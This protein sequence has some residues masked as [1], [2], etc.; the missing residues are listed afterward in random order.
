MTKILITGGCGFIGSNLV[1][2]LIEK[3]DWNISIL[4][5]LSIGKKEDIENI[6]G[7][8]ERTTIIKGDIRKK[9][10]IKKAIEGCEYVVNLAAQVGVM[11]SVDDPIFDA[12]VN[13]IGTINV[14][15]A[16]VDNNI[17]KIVHASSVAPLGD[18]EMPID[19]TKLPHPLSPYAASKLAGES[20]CS[21][22]S[23]SHEISTVALRFSNVYGPKSYTRGSVIPLFIRKI[24]DKKQAT[25]YGK[26]AQTR[27]FIY[28]KDICKGIFLSLTKDL[29]NNFELIQLATGKETSIN[30]LFD[31]LKKEL[32]SNNIDIKDP[33]YAPERPGEIARNYADISKAKDLLGFNPEI[34]L[35]KGIKNTVSWFIKQ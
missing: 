26:G 28:V 7:S 31:T 8:K 20:Y 17:K 19:E 33:K 5:N 22:F 9:E 2:F 10:D 18:Q 30:Q 25:I 35:S 11:P 27:D 12:D 32:E 21:A 15:Q 34:D 4:D 24:L 6:E 13:I 3:T 29:K 1:E 16:A 23:A 14:L